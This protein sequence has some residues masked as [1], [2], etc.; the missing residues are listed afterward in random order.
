MKKHLIIIIPVIL[1][2]ILIFPG[3]EKQ[4]D[5]K[6][7]DQVTENNFFQTPQQ[8][9]ATLAQAYTPM[10]GIQMPPGGS[11]ILNEVS[12][13]ELIVPTRGN[14]WYDGGKWQR[15]WTHTPLYT[16]ADINIAWSSYASGTTACNFVLNLLNS[17]PP[18]NKP[19]NTAQITAEIKVL[20]AYYLLGLMDL[21]GNIPLVTDFNT[22]PSKVVQSTPSA[23]YAFLESEL[24]TNVPLLQ[25]PSA[26]NYGHMT[27]YGGYMVLAHLYLNAQ[28]YTGTAEWTKALSAAD[29]VI[30]SGAY[31]LQPNYLDNFIVANQGSLENIFVIPFNN[32]YIGGNNWEAMTLHYSN[33]YTYN[34]TGQ[35][36]NGF[37]AP[38]AFYRS[39]TATDTRTKMWELG[40]QYSSSG[41]ILTDLGTGLLCIISP[42]VLQLS[43]PADSFRLAGARSNKYAPQPGTNGMQSNSGVVY[44]LGEA[45]LIKAEAELRLGDASD[46]LTA[47]NAIRARAEVPAWGLSDLTLPNLL[48]ERGRE[49]AWEN[50][51]RDD[52]IRFEVA[53]KVPYFT[54]ARVPGK[55]QDPDQHTFLFP[56]PQA[57]MNTNPN[58]K[59]NT[60]Y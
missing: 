23:V 26:A 59:Q 20:R 49:M 37:C 29:T 41:A 2:A 40:Q 51:R 44:R 45:Y 33:M 24:L 52:L 9:N 16:D 5:S 47:V 8:V 34:L 31:S 14:D 42:Y 35:P 3:C 7:Y 60:G 12:T 15:Y 17:L 57:Q 50:V 28:V 22:V 39:F 43:N 46:A 58:L 27:K 4:L 30:N 6:V 25:A 53:D 48:A 13:D 56:I 32:N 18:A 36:D 1:L 19:S 38:T 10:T 55:S 54:G 21:F 11:F